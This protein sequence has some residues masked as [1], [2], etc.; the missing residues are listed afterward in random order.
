VIMFVLFQ[1]SHNSNGNCLDCVG[2][3]LT[4]EHQMR[5][6]TR[7]DLK[8]MKVHGACLGYCVIS[9]HF[10]HVTQIIG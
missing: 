8:T 4:C 9:L 7:T 3:L 2:H 6:V 5:R 1:P 10:L